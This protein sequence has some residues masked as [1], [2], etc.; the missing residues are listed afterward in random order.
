MKKAGI[1][2][3][4]L[5]LLMG[6]A[7]FAAA[8]DNDDA[9][10]FM[11]E[12]ITVTAQ[13]REENQQKVAIAM[14]VISAEDIQQQGM[15]N[16][17]ELLSNVSNVFINKSTDGMRITLRGLSDNEGLS[18]TNQH[19]STPTVA[20]NIDGA[21]NSNSNAGHPLFRACPCYIHVTVVYEKC[22]SCE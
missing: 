9:D 14:D 15:N 11:L 12:E 4:A 1:S 2:L 5:C 16:V 22:P 3:M 8:Q 18:T 17:D 10:E 7:F 21:Y 13:K 19:Q 20:V 6:T